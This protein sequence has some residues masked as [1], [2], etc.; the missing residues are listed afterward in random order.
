MNFV[1]P[2]TISGTLNLK[3]PSNTPAAGFRIGARSSFA[4]SD[5]DELASALVA[6]DGTFTFSIPS[7][8]AP[9]PA[10]PDFPNLFFQAFAPGGRF[11]AST[12][13][14]VRPGQGPLIPLDPWL[15][16]VPLATGHLVTNFG[17]TPRMVALQNSRVEPLIDNERAWKAL[18][19]AIAG[20]QTTVELSQLYMDV[21]HAGR[22]QVYATFAGDPTQ[23]AAGEPVGQTIEQLL[24]DARGRPNVSVQV[25]LNDF[26]GVGYPVDTADRAAELFDH[27]GVRL[28]RFVRPLRM[29]MHAKLAVIDGTTGFTIGSPFLAEYYDGMGHAIDGARRGAMNGLRNSIA[30]PI[31]D[32]SVLIEGEGA[33]HLRETFY[34][35]WNGCQEAQGP[36]PYVD[37]PL[38]PVAQPVCATQIVR[39][40]PGGNTFPRAPQPAG[41]PAIADPGAGETGVLES[42]QRAIA[43]ATEVVYLENQY[44]HEP[45]ILDALIEA[46]RRSPTLEVIA[47]INIRVD[48]PEYLGKQRRA[49]ARLRKDAGAAAARLGIFTRWSHEAEPRPRVIR[50]YIHAKVAV[51]DDKWAT[52]GSANLDSISLRSSDVLTDL[53]LL[54]ERGVTDRSVEVNAA[55]FNDVDGLP[56]SGVPLQL[57]RSLWAHHLGLSPDDPALAARPPGGWLSLWNAAAAARLADLKAVPPIAEKTR[58]HP[59]CVLPYVDEPEPLKNLAALGVPWQVLYSPPVLEGE[60]DPPPLLVMDRVRSFD[61]VTRKWKEG[62]PPAAPR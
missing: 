13:Q 12:S 49:V 7:A 51:V 55:L 61:W 40:L 57:R 29:V 46:L 27:F 8:P 19:D 53:P 21:R 41:V 38:T 6:A 10:A 2:L 22:N 59:G 33:R 45:A 3:D 28:R 34:L 31:H 36:E 24:Q 50:T 39:T 25:V 32:V 16:S 23:P 30:T 56:K 48:I 54:G 42:Y 52:I 62:I 60:P 1:G 14:R 20:A 44:F 11:L 58:L 35:I 9:H 17:D 43:L 15:L 37:P 5:R 18:A 47:L 4:L 26:T